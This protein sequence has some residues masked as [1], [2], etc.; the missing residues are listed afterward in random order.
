MAYA[1]TA[2]PHLLVASI[3]N[4]SPNLWGY[5]PGSTDSLA[6]IAASNFFSNGAALGMKVRDFVLVS[7]TTGSTTFGV[8]YVTTVNAS[9]AATVTFGAGTT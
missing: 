3:G 4:R 8:G 5:N 2:G 6:Q 1:S 9:S 7:A